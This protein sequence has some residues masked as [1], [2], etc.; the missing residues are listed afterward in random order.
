V[1]SRVGLYTCMDVGEVGWSRRDR[2]ATLKLD[3]VASGMGTG[4]SVCVEVC[5]TSAATG[6]ATHVDHNNFQMWSE[7]CGHHTT[8]H[9]TALIHI[10]IDRVW[11]ASARVHTCPQHTYMQPAKQAHAD[12]PTELELRGCRVMTQVERVEQK[13]HTTRQWCCGKALDLA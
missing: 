6:W 1:C 13:A 12:V 8:F 3:D 7:F 4:A 2:R 10:P 9:C 11:I 5:A